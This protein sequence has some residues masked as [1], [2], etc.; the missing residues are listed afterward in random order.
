MK[1]K[2]STDG[3]PRVKSKRVVADSGSS[4]DEN[5]VMDMSQNPDFNVDVSLQASIS[6]GQSQAQGS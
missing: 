2:A 6:S 1:R 3:G 5:D 4:G